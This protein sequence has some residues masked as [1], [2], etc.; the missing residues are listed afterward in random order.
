MLS[1]KDGQLSMTTD[2]SLT[3]LKAELFQRRLTALGRCYNPPST[4]HREVLLC[5][6][7]LLFM[8]APFLFV[9]A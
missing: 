7:E 4:L 5:P 8:S 6:S 2:Y 1:R 3:R 9:T